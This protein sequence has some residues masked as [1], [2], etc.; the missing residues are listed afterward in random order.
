[1][2]RHRYFV[3]E[4]KDCSELS[5]NEGKMTLLQKCGPQIPN[6]GNLNVLYHSMAGH[7]RTLKGGYAGIDSTSARNVPTVSKGG[8]GGGVGGGGSVCRVGGWGW[9]LG[10]LAC[11]AVN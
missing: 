1:M 7:F 9:G 10:S 5:E 6:H 11:A 4:V 3:A 8:G 2:L